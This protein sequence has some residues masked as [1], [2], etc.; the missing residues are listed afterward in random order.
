MTALQDLSTTKGNQVNISIVEDHQ[1]LKLVDSVAHLETQ[2][3]YAWF[4]NRMI[5]ADIN[6]AFPENSVTA[7]IGPSGCGKSTFI[8]VKPFAG[9]T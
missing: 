8:R 3:L 7:L 9:K 4:G 6:L 5:L 1:R 2:G